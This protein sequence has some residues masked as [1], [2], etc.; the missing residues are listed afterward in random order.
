MEHRLDA[1]T[2]ATGDPGLLNRNIVLQNSVKFGSVNADRYHYELAAN[3]LAQADPGWLADVITRQ[4]PLD[5]WED[6]YA[7]RPDD[8]EAVLTFADA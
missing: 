4:V 6:A 1:W 3:A 7:R 5:Q 2:G 8:I